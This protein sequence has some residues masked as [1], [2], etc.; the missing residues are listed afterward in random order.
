MPKELLSSL[1]IQYRK[2]RVSALGHAITEH[3][4]RNKNG[5]GRVEE[6]GRRAWGD[7]LELCLQ[8]EF[9]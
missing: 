9:L 3:S 6:R 8:Q 5:T 2:C 7:K 1:G 4:N